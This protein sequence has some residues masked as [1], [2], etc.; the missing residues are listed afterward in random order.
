[1][2]ALAGDAECQLLLGLIYA[3][4]DGFKKRRKYK[5][6]IKWWTLGAE[7]GDAQCQM[8]LSFLY[9][10]GYGVEKDLAKSKKLAKLASKEIPNARELVADFN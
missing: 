3:D 4:G 6:A 8:G 1:M 2:G 5:M 9:K 10:K 7:Q